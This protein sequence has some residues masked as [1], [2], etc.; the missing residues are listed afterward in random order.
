VGGT[1][2]FPQNQPGLRRNP[3]HSWRGGCQQPEGVALRDVA[4]KLGPKSSAQF[5]EEIQKELL[6][7]IILLRHAGA[8]YGESAEHSLLYFRYSG[9]PRKSRPVSLTLYSLLCV[10][11]PHGDT[12]A[13][14]DTHSTDIGR[15][16]SGKPL[17]GIR[18]IAKNQQ[19]GGAPSESREIRG[20]SR[21]AW[22]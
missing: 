8:A 6:G 12:D 13:G 14:L 4:L 9:E 20:I 11:Q 16:P 7:R 15:L 5:Q 18:S 19:K 17:V 21:T 2:R 3:C 1:Q 10:G 22:R